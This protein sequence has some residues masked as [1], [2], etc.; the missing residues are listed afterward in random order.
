V[1]FLLERKNKVKISKNNALL[2]VLLGIVALF[3]AIA[4]MRVG[5]L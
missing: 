2:V 4:V 5:K 3:Y 1:N